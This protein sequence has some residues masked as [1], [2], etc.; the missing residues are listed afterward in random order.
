[1]PEPTLS[2]VATT[3]R[4]QSLDVRHLRLV[5]A[6]I[7][8]GSLTRAAERLNL[9]Q[10]AL[11]HQLK[12]LEL[13]LDVPLFV[14]AKKRLVPTA[15][16]E[17]L[18]ARARPIMSELMAL[19]DDLRSRAS[20]WRGTLRLATECY[21]LY[22]WLPP[23]LRRFHR[24]HRNVEVDIVA[25]ATDNAGAALSRGEID[26]A[27]VSTLSPTPSM[28]MHRLFTDEILLV[29]AND[30]ELATKAYVTPA[31]IVNER[32]LLFTPPDRN[33]F[34]QHLFRDALKPREVQVMKLT[35]AILSMVRAGLGVTA[36]ARWAVADQLRTRRVTGVRIGRNGYYREWHAATLVQ[37][38]RAMPRYITDF[39]ELLSTTALPAR[40]DE[41]VTPLLAQ[42]GNSKR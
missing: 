35:E 30:H 33:W 8:E 20:G 3:F 18:I 17:E 15:A 26:L 23:I 21:T 24:L 5:T 41:R 34:Y 37:R 4:P 39:I 29:V 36:A 22:E 42:R 25:D 19:E 27:I 31:D 40:F 12:D 7:D 1:M 13:S 28:S 2:P 6:I 11:S 9:T 16:G 14:R 10:S 38:R 32:L